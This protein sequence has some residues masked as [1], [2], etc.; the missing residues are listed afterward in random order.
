M[1]LGLVKLIFPNEHNV[2]LHGTP[3][4][5]RFSRCPRDFSHGRIWVD[6]FGVYALI[7]ARMRKTQGRLISVIDP[8]PKPRP[9]PFCPGLF[10][11]RLSTDALY[12]RQAFVV[13]EK[14]LHVS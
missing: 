12:Q 9:V 13:T 5:E 2:Y 3:S 8:E 14:V 4:Q 11:G 1:P 7:P 10:H 6:A